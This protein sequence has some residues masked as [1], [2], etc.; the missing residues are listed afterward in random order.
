MKCENRECGSNVNG[1]CQFEAEGDERPSFCKL[2]SLV[3][4]VSKLDEY[5]QLLGEELNECAS[6][7]HV[8]GWKSTR[9][10]KG[11]QIRLQIEALR[12]KHNAQFEPQKKEKDNA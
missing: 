8:H 6:I 1:W 12:G 9:E 11:K 3:G 10:E 2:N 7:A 4:V 5:I